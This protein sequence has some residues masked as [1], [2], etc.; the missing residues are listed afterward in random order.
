MTK[1][2]FNLLVVSLSIV[3]PLTVV[4]T[5]ISLLDWPEYQPF[6]DS[7]P[8]NPWKEILGGSIW[9]TVF[10][11]IFTF[12]CISILESKWIKE[13]K[14]STQNFLKFLT[15]AVYFI[16]FWLMI[17]YIYLFSWSTHTMVW[18]GVVLGLPPFTDLQFY[19]LPGLIGLFYSCF[20]A[21]VYKRKNNFLT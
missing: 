21:L 18:G 10:F 7:L 8:Y 16:L 2:E 15:I 13:K 1:R 6:F 12:I 11:G 20:I 4:S 14:S 5:F 9:N 3:A 19:L 17:L